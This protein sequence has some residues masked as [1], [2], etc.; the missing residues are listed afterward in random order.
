MIIFLIVNDKISYI[1]SRYLV[2]Y[3]LLM[4]IVP[5]TTSNTFS[6]MVRFRMGHDKLWA[7]TAALCTCTSSHFDGMNGQ[8]FFGTENIKVLF[9]YERQIE[10]I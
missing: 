7:R 3:I 2:L 8:S 1:T 10:E 6:R 4:L 9:Q 5:V